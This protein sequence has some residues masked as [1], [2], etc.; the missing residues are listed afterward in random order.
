MNLLQYLL[1][2]L[3]LLHFDSYDL[4]PQEQCL[5][6]KLTSTQ[7]QPACP[8]CGQPS[9]RVHSR[10]SRTL[11]DLPCVSFSLRLI[12]QVCK[13]FCSNPAC[14]RRI[15]TERFAEVAA[16]WARKTQRLVEHLQAIALAS[17]GQAGAR[18]CA[19]MGLRCCGSTLLNLLKAL[20]LPPV[21]RL[22][23]GRRR[24]CPTPRAALW[25]DPS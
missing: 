8:I 17:G 18:L 2:S 12:V 14:P 4:L 6:L 25:H 10:Y 23:S 3:H 1:P 13:F 11:A 16:P 5:T 22:V 19:Y 20:P 24:F 21:K 15:F 9:D 7:V